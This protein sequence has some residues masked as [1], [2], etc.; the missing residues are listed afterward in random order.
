[1]FCSLQ[2]RYDSQNRKQKV[3]CKNCGKEFYK[4]AGQIQKH[5]NS[6]CCHSCSATY[7]NKYKNPEVIY[8]ETGAA[9]GYPEVVPVDVDRGWYAA[10]K[11]LTAFGENSKAYDASGFPI[12][13]SLFLKSNIHK[14]KSS[15]AVLWRFL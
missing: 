13:F 1:M 15:T 9:K 6:F 4:R 10:T 11:P 14:A 3:T 12:Y 5:P 2:C 7:N 8:Y